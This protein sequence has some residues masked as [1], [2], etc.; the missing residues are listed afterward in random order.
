METVNIVVDGHEVKVNKGAIILAAAQQAG[1]YVPTLCSHPDLESGTECKLCLV[2]IEGKPGQVTACNTP[3]TEGMVVRTESPDIKTARRAALQI[4]LAQHPNACLS[5][6]RL[7][8]CGPNDI[9]LRSVAVAER[10]V[11]CPN[12]EHCELQNVS[13]YIGVDNLWSTYT[14]KNVP[15]DCGDPLFIR[16]YNL[17]VACGRCVRVCKGVRGVGAV[18]FIQK[19]GKKE[20]GTPAGKP[21]AESGCRFCTACVEVCP[22]A[23]LLDRREY[24]TEAEREAAIVPCRNAC[25]LGIDVPRYVRL[26][27][28]RKYAKSLAVIAE[29]LPF[30]ILCGTVCHHPCELKCRRG[31]LNQPVSIRALKRFVAER[32]PEGG[33]L[34]IKFVPPTGKKVAIIGAGPAGMVAAYYLSMV[35]GHSV[36]IFEALPQAGGMMRYGIPSYR[37]PRNVLDS[38]VDLVKQC[39]VDIKLNTRVESLDE[40]F[41]QGYSAI[42]VAL[43]AHRGQKLGVEGEENKG[44]VDGAAFLRDVSL[45]KKMNVGEKVAVVGGGNVAIDS[46]RTALRLGA[47]EVAIIYRRTRAEMP[48]NPEE[49]EGAIEEKIKLE[50]LSAPTKISQNNGRLQLTCVKMQLGEPDASGRRRPEPV[51]GSE[52]NTDYDTIIA[53]IGQVP[54]IP[55][56]YGLDI[57]RG[58]II[59]SDPATLATNRPGVFAGGDVVTGPATVSGAMAAGR[60][61]AMSIDRYL[62]GSGDISEQ[63]TTPD[64]VSPCLGIEE[65]FAQKPRQHQR[66]IEPDERHGFIEVELGLDEEKAVTEAQRCLRCDLRLQIGKAKPTPVEDQVEEILETYAR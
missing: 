23:A 53:A 42:F 38:Q 15:T 5:C 64:E 46:A 12:N 50:F 36:T 39:G 52:F 34:R 33:V 6:N 63:L 31:E 13:R 14:P 16:N 25:P 57:D 37:L 62:G 1:V 60:K 32:P 18:D 20:V 51:K 54:D 24:K 28:E 59:K 2:E 4:V 7:K 11:T 66:C 30:P 35:R 3:V 48:A 19:N 10:C 9:C 56:P 26:I 58:N 61:A 65:G 47:K 8:H 17:C 41:N 44:V 40:L 29:K 21:L 55:K 43:G 27:A 22:T 45:G 49:V